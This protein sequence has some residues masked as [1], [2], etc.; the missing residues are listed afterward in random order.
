AVEIGGLVEAVQLALIGEHE[1]H[2][3]AADEIE[4][5]R[6]IT[7]DAECV[8]QSKGDVA[9]G[10]VGD[11][12]RLEESFLRVRWIPEI[13]LK[14]DDLSSSNGVCVDVVR[15]QVLRGAEVGIHG[16]L[17]I[18]RDQY[19]ATCCRRAGGCR[20]R[21]KRDPGGTN[22]VGK[23]A[24]ELVVLDLADEACSCTK[25]CHTYDGIRG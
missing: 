24:A 7:I 2:G 22:V 21:R 15:M 12:R 8:R 14:I 11:L 23:D 9:L 1:V 25:A 6:A 3:A 18:R 17:A 20:W 10:G 5:L 4:E 16:A 13:T 19:V